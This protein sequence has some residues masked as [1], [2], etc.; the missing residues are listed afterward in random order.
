MMWHLSLPLINRFNKTK[1][2]ISSIQAFL[3]KDFFIVS[4]YLNLQLLVF[5][6]C[7]TTINVAHTYIF[8]VPPISWLYVVCIG[9]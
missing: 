8:S 5:S 2:A 1:A 6:A 4:D 9:K 3:P 7:V